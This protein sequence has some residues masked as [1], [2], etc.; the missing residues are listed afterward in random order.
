MG[1]ATYDPLQWSLSACDPRDGS[2]AGSQCHRKHPPRRL[3]QLSHEKT[4]GFSC[5][6]FQTGSLREPSAAGRVGK[7]RRPG[8]QPKKRQTQQAPAFSESCGGKKKRDPRAS[9]AQRVAWGE[10]GAAE[11]S[12]RNGSRQKRLPFL[13]R[14][15]LA[16]TWCGQQ[17]SNLHGFPLE[18]KSSVSAN[19]TMPAY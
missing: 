6:I 3:R 13:S 17:D 4:T 5:S 18:P 14:T 9:P 8:T 12:R 2:S 1:A 10:G 11:Y 15:E 16:P 19:S 7:R